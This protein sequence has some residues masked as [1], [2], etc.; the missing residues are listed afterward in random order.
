MAPSTY[1]PHHLAL[2]AGVSLWHRRLG[3][4]DS[5]I[6]RSLSSFGF[7]N[8]IADLTTLCHAFKVGKHTRLPVVSS[9]IVVTEPFQIIHSDIWTS[10]VISNSGF[11]YYHLFLDH[12]SHFV[13]VYP[14]HRKSDSFAKFLNFSAYV[15]MQFNGPIQALQCDNGG[16]YTSRVFLDYLA[17]TGTNSRFSCPYTSQQNG[18]AERMLRTINN[19]VRAL[20]I[21]ANMPHS[22]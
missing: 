21:Q 9:S 10:P 13:W 14:L 22:Y 17:S 7:S 5:T 16:E 20:L 4:P 15:R 3:H 19:L 2:T 12:Y 18:R 6:N 8:K 11:K 1:S